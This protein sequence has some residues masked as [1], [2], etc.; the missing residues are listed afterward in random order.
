MALHRF[1]QIEGG[2]LV[3]GVV[4]QGVRDRFAN[5]F[6]RGEMDNRVNLLLL[7]NGFGGGLIAQVDL[8]KSRPL[9][10]NA[11]NMVD[12]L[13]AAIAEAIDDDSTVAFLEQLN[14]GVAA[15]V[16]G[17]AGNEY[18]H[19]LYHI[20]FMSIRFV[21]RDFGGFWRITEKDFHGQV[22][23]ES[24]PGRGTRFVLQLHDSPSGR[25]PL[26]SSAGSAT[27]TA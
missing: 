25:P 21:A 16:T 9:A 14:H 27:I 13:A 10:T 20:R 1:Q 24:A 15:N 12:R 3:I 23:I 8:V 7:E 2:E 5:G 19:S 4:V 6:Q 17:T 18:F 26:Q 22:M 11:L